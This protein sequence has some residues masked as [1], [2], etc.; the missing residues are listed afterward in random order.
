MITVS[1]VTAGVTGLI[2]VWVAS[3][4]NSFSVSNNPSYAKK[5]VIEKRFLFNFLI[6]TAVMMPLKS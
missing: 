2:T 1:L 4:R 3:Y 5:S 6:H